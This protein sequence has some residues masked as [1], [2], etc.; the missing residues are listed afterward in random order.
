MK[1]LIQ[2]VTIIDPNS[3][4]NG[5]KRDILI[6]NGRIITIREGISTSESTGADLVIQGSGYH[7]SPGWVDIFSHFCDP[8][9]EYKETLETGSRAAAA[10]GYTDVFVIPNTRPVIDT[11]SQVEY[12]R[13]QSRWLPVNIWPIGAMTRGLEGKDLAEMYDMRN[14][15]AIAFSD[16]T[17]P[18]QSAGLLLKGLQYVKAFDGVIIQVPDDRSVG[19]NGLMNEG[20]ISTRL[21]LPGK[22]MMA[23]ELIIARDIK[24]ARYTGSG[25]HFTGVTSPR[26]LDY[27]RRAKDGGLAVSCSVTPYHLSFTDA[28]LVNYDTNLKVFPPLRDQHSVDSLKKAVLDGTIDC[29]ASHHFP[30][31]YDSKIVEFEY[32]RPGMIGLETTYAAVRTALPE[33]SP[34]K[35]VNLLS[36]NARRL[37]AME[38]PSLAE[39]QTCSLTLFDPEGSTLVQEKTILSKSKNTA[40]TGQELKGKVI[41][42]INGEK[43]ILNNKGTD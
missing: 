4:H 10:G 39:G 9:Y 29:I 36:L 31:E 7:V 14:S 34:E 42:V 32:A 17:H 6:E 11:K 22:P 23:E 19:S 35:I 40:F 1:I 21:G 41:G 28:A 30:H 20:I 15:G 37:F 33:L 38:Q 18:V 5:T 8:G 12:I 16:G 26:S 13:Q 27:I 43:I 3:S 2:Q 24:L 25:I